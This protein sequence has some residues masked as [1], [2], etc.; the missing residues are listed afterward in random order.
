MPLCK[1]QF[2]CRQSVVIQR[3]I[4]YVTLYTNIV[5]SVARPQ[6]DVHLVAWAKV[7]DSHR[8][9]VAHAER[10]G[11]GETRCSYAENVNLFF[12]FVIVIDV[13]IKIHY[14]NDILCCLILIYSHTYVNIKNLVLSKCYKYPL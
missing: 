11:S 7:T 1:K 4:G 9:L 10:L 5:N 6:L 3:P 13:T 8:Q 2:Y 12:H 14:S